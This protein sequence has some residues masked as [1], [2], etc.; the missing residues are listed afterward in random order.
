MK[1]LN[2]SI[3]TSLDLNECREYIA[4]LPLGS[5]EYHG[6]HLPI[7]IDSLIALRLAEELSE[8]LDAINDVCILILQPINYGFSAEWSDLFSISLR[9]ETLLNILRDIY[10]SMS[11]TKGFKGLLVLNAHGG[12]TSVVD[13]FI[14]EATF[15]LRGRAVAVDLWRVARQL[16]LEYCHACRLE[17]ELAKYLGVETYGEG[18]VSEAR[19]SPRDY[20][21]YMNARSGRFGKEPCL[22]EFMNS[23]INAFKEAI[24][25]ILKTSQ[26]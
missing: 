24:K 6:K 9:P 4:V 15:I 17:V 13:V 5:L 18:D 22:S 16:G 7:A 14:R 8:R 12:N 11:K 19:L 23:L 21:A 2:A 26:H 10:S 3:S 25:H 1:I 20:I